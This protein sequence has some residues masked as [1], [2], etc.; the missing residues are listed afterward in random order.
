MGKSY[1]S[2][3]IL[4]FLFV[5]AVSSSQ[6]LS[7]SGVL[8]GS[9]KDTET[10]EA[11]PGVNVRLKATSF[12][13]STDEKGEFRIGGIPQGTY[14][15][16]ISAVGYETI[17][18]GISITAGEEIRREFL[19]R[20]EAIQAGDVVVYGASLRRERITEAPASVRVL[21]AK[22]IAR[23]AGTG[24]LPKLL[25]SQPGVDIVQSGLFDFNLNT[26]GFNT[27][28]NRRI[29]VLLDGRD[30]GTAFLGAPE[31]N[32]LSIPVEEMG[33][34]ELVC[35]PGSALYGANAYN[36][37]LNVSTFPPRANQGTRLTVGGGELNSV[38]GDFRHA[39]AAGKWSY[40]VNVG[41]ASGKS[42]SR[43]RTNAQFEYPSTYPLNPVINNEVV[44]LDLNPVQQIYASARLDYDYAAGGFATVEAGIT[45]VKNE[46]YV[47]GIGRVQAQNAL[48]PWGR[49]SYQG[50]GLNVNLW[51]NLRRNEKPERSLATGLDLTQN[52]TITQGE[53]QYSFGALE[54]NV[55]FVVGASHRLVSIDTK[56]TLMLEPRDDNMSGF[57]GQAEYKI[58][59]DFKAI[60]A[61]RWD[62]STLHPSQFSPKAAV[63]W[64]FM[65][66]QSVRLTFNKAFQSPNYSELY[67]YVV[68]P[69]RPLAYFGNL[70]TNPPGLTG[71][72]GGVQPGAPKDLTVEKITGYEVGYKGIFS[73]TLFITLDAYY[74]QMTDFVTDLA[75]GV[76][77]KYPA[78]GLFSYD[79]PGSSRTIWSYINAGRVNELGADL[80]ITYYLNDFWHI[81][82][83]YSFFDFEILEKNQ[84]DILI[85]NSPKY[86]LSGGITYAHP[87]GHDANLTVKYVPTFPWAAGV[88]QGEIP[89][90]AVVN[91][92]GNYRFSERISFNLAISNLLDRQHWEIFGGSIIGRRALG[93]VTV[94]L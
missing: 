94:T 29:L 41:G 44:D 13:A 28:L 31:W 65:Q 78:P 46:V 40:R 92:G 9:V 32:G 2:L 62:R 49:I 69:T 38:R 68:H 53:V 84:N 1:A 77:P 37:V 82:A 67:L 85:P 11:I 24:Q 27:S 81:D 64:S 10:R 8:T 17:E 7:Q 42:F 93:S 34:V 21:D 72:Q 89:A 14:T 36:G 57:Y 5:V 61:A 20:S 23:N 26:R 90:Y 76:N 39:A 12:G 58:A 51:T 48:R 43:I 45:Q 18:S 87:D 47:T 35:G 56:G 80:G 73:N 91:F 66:G 70:V 16:V 86:R 75:A 6:V 50:H 74:N 60:L 52:A 88:F 3:R 54:N 15:V 79:P 71:F 25:E 59:E 4:A 63:V 83:S 19:I 30:L 22:E 55:L 33:R